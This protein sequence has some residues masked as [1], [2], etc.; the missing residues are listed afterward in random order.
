MPKQ[1]DR[2]LAGEL[3]RLTSLGRKAKKTVD[4]KKLLARSLI[5]AG[6][7]LPSLG[8]G[9]SFKTDFRA[10]KRPGEKLKRTLVDTMIYG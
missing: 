4:S 10:K 9:L 6:T 8:K 5:N 3:P 1:P 7:K 2:E